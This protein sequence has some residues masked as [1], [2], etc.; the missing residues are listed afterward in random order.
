MQIGPGCNNNANY[1]TAFLNARTKVGKL[2]S[3]VDAVLQPGAA[4]SGT[5][6]DVH[7]NPVSDMC[8]D[9]SGSGALT[10]SVYA[11]GG[12]TTGDDGSYV[13]QRAARRD[14]RDRLL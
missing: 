8:I 3:G 13:S 6:T 10:A 1:T 14:L 5:V 11:S 12:D 9:V 7:G 4:I 2:T